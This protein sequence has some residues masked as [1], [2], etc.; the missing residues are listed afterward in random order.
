MKD[1]GGKGGYYTNSGLDMAQHEETRSA[2]CRLSYDEIN[3]HLIGTSSW[4][5]QAGGATKDGGDTKDFGDINLVNLGD[6]EHWAN[7]SISIA[8]VQAKDGWVP[9]ISKRR[10]SIKTLIGD[11]KKALNNKVAKELVEVAKILMN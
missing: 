9:K 11:F 3:N 5:I 6:I 7:H 8:R 2:D 10:V 4:Y 1:I